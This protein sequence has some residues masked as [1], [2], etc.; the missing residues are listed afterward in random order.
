MRKKKVL[1]VDDHKELSIELVNLFQA[2]G[3]PSTCVFDGADAIKEI[4]SGNY[5]LVFLDF[6]LP[7]MT[8]YE[9]MNDILKM[10]KKPKVVIMTGHATVES[11][12]DLLKMGAVH[13]CKKPFQPES[14]IELVK[15]HVGSP[16]CEEVEEKVCRLISTRLR[17]ARQSK[18][19]TIKQLAQKTHLSASLLSQIETGKISPSLSSLIRITHNLQMPLKSL[20][21]G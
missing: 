14:L 11:A 3:Y 17:S 21:D 6:K 15:T 5:S 12:V 20:F 2:S 16:D 10:R 19:L 13:Y 18:K 7:D 8:A 1:V 9:V 4:T